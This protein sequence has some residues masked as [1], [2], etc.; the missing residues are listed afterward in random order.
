MIFQDPYGSLNPRR[1]VGSIIGDPFAI[2]KTATGAGAQAPGAGGDGARRAQPRALQPV[3]GRVL[4]RAAAAHRRG[5][6]AGAP[7]QADRLRRA[8]VGARRVHPGADHQPAGRP[9]GRAR[10]HLHLHRPRP[11]RRAAR[12]QPGR[13]DVPR[14]GD[15][16]GAGRASCGTTRG[17][18][19]PTPCCRP[20]APRPGQVARSASGSSWSA[21][22]P[23]RSSRPRAAGST[24]AAP[25]R[26]RTAWTQD[27]ELEPR[28][29]D[30]P[31]HLAACHFPV[32]DGEDI[33]KARPSLAAED[34]VIE[35]GLLGRSLEHAQARAKGTAMS[36]R[37]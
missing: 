33:S 2:H 19:T 34:R 16:A 14:Q 7:A 24:P 32:E 21:T 12:E 11:V 23:R 26:A 37:A 13:G 20:S 9:A 6:G 8:G 18:R 35:P 25:R 31:D 36:L 27:P 5:Q 28:L 3:P 10:P 15:R 29:G 17:T 1:R 4:R 30:A 22:C